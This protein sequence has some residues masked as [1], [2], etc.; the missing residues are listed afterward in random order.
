MEPKDKENVNLGQH[1]FYLTFILFK[2]SKTKV[3]QTC[4]VI[5]S[6]SSLVSHGSHTLWARA[7]SGKYHGVHCEDPY[8]FE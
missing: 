6:D 4:F 8:F 7:T 5:N 2:M 1:E 3:L